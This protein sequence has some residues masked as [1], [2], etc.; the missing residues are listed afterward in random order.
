MTPN[1]PQ[2]QTVTILG[3]R[4]PVRTSE[5]NK[6][7]QRAVS[8]LREQIDSVKEQAPEATRL[9]VALLSALNLAGRI[10][11]LENKPEHTGL[12]PE[13]LNE[14]NELEDT[15]ETLINVKNP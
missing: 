5:Q 13:T 10:V 15:I 11:Q 1:N 14:I 3:E 9:Q 6:D 7:P 2:H 4:L 12:S 8:L